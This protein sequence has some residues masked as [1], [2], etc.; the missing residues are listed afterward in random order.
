MQALTKGSELNFMLDM[1][2]QDAILERQSADPPAEAQHP[3]V[4]GCRAIVAPYVNNVYANLDMPAIDFLVLLRLGHTHALTLCICSY[5]SVYLRSRRV[6]V[7]GPSHRIYLDGCAVSA[8]SQ[9]DTPLGAIPVDTKGTYCSFVPYSVVNEL[10]ATSYFTVMPA[11][12]D[13]NEHSIEMQF[14]YL[15]KV[16]EK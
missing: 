8:F 11:Q 1:W 12:V 2:L 7:L 14:P 10:L 6:F 13:K 15:R 5:V 9:V 4:Q 3:L 16:F